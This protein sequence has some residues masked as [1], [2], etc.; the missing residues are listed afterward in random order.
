VLVTF[1]LLNAV[2][3]LAIA[4]LAL[5]DALSLLTLAILVLLRGCFG[6][7][8]VLS[9]IRED[10]GEAERQGPAP[11][12]RKA[13]KEGLRY[14]YTHPLLRWYA[15]TL[16]L[17]FVGNALV[18]T[19]LVFYALRDLRLGP[20]VVGVCLAIGGITGVVG[21]GLSDRLSLRFGMGRMLLV[22]H[23][24]LPLA[25][26]LLILARSG[27]TATLFLAGVQVVVGF[28]LGVGSPMELSWRNTITRPELR[29]RMNGTIRSVNWGM[30]TISGPVAGA[31][32]AAA[33]TRVAMVV[34]IV[35][36]LVVA[37]VFAC[38]PMRS[39]RMPATEV[40]G[41]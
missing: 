32:A 3:L 4:A 40:V 17:W 33:G 41:G 36:L 27:G 37:V 25:Y 35:V 28:V 29:G 5:A 39:V 20:A 13:I 24:I 26:V 12:I 8:I 21:A 14:V 9:G 15:G 30:N 18:S 10:A 2:I 16:H 34:G 22:S 23:V 1:D 38:S 31:V 19:L 11:A 7:A 6:S